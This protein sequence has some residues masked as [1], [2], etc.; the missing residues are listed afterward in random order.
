MAVLAKNDVRYTLTG[1]RGD[2]VMDGG[3][4]SDIDACL[5]TGAD[6][7]VSKIADTIVVRAK[8]EDSD[9]V[10]ALVNIERIDFTDGDLAFDVTTPPLLA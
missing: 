1:G 3:A 7:S 4:G 8:A 5:A 6:Y 10:D 9:G 2:D